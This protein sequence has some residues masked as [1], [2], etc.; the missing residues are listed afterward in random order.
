MNDI[1]P[2]APRWFKSSY[3]NGS[4]GECVECAHTPEATLVRDSKHPGRPSLVVAVEGWKAFI[5]AMV[6]NRLDSSDLPNH[7]PQVDNTPTSSA[8]GA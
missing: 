2:S 6:T 4:G 5:D 8:V 1:A 7:P 3:S